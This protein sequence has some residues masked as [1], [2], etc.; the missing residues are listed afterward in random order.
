MLAGVCT[1][2]V[3][4]AVVYRL[5]LYVTGFKIQGKLDKYNDG[6]SKLRA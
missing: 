4:L 5:P 6:S 1:A 2:A 3:S